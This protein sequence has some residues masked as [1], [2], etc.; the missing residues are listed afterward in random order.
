MADVWKELGN[1]VGRALKPLAEIPTAMWKSLQEAASDLAKGFM[2]AAA[3]VS[4]AMVPLI[5]PHMEE[6]MEEATATL[7][8]GSPK[9]EVK[10]K[11]DKLTKAL[12]KAL[13]KNIPEKGESPPSLEALLVATSAIISTNIGLDIG[14]Y[15]V[16]MGLDLVHPI[17]EMGFRHAGMKLLD[18]FQ[19]PSMIGPS[20]QA[21]VWSG[22]IAPL[23]MRWNE[24]FPYLV[25]GTAILPYMRAKDIITSEDYVLN[26]KF[27]AFDE[28]WSSAML[29]NTARYPSFSDLR[30]MIHRTDLTWEDAEVALSKS[31]IHADY[32]AKYEEL[33]PAIP[34]S[35][36]LITM[37]VREVITKAK[38]IENMKLQGFSA[39]W[40][41]NYY[42]NHWILLP[43]SEVKKARHRDDIDDAEL[44]KFLVLHDYKPD[45]R[46][47]I[48]TSDAGLA[49]G[50]IWDRPGRI[51]SRWMFRWGE[52]D[53]TDLRDFLVDDGLDPA[54]ADRVAMAVA[55]NQFLSDINRQIGNAKASFVK[56]YS[57][58]ATL[59]SD[60]TALGLRSE[61]VEYHVVD[62]LADRE[63]AIHDE[64]LRTL[65]AQY[66]R[67][68]M[69]MADVITAVE[70]I[71]VDEVAR[72]AW[73]KALPT[74]KQVVI[75][76]E[77]FGTE[78]NRLV[79][80]AKYDYVR[81]YT[82]KPNMVSRMTLLD[83]PTEVIEFH[84][85]DADEDRARGH[86]DKSLAIIEEGYIDDLISWELVASMAKEILVDVDGL[87][88]FL[89]GVWLNKHKAVR[90][91]V[92]E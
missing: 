63:R 56:G 86:K 74:A 8:P 18:S 87:N 48:K 25:P 82:T 42:E 76:E 23:R 69:T 92:G 68:A 20:L 35:G 46:P 30:T 55:K 84:V 41:D 44:S 10:E 81:G 26:M 79:A 32:V 11:A 40:A 77:T 70:P 17:K 85:M 89:D 12:M 3:G 21:P 61:M 4:E 58:E 67:G 75:M 80:N 50:L 6:L 38:F 36:D 33:L 47:D 5:A 19:L 62:A 29:A 15:G 72:D 57:V 83:L 52:I 59:R 60:I 90:V 34:G 88:L 91:F 45:P 16:T 27:N 39:E 53:A 7:L 2:G 54:Y 64:E 22:V 14:L 51:E 28:T 66:A 71:I 49:A 31:L 43:L 73:L 37:M 9:K 78:V 24:K 1:A 65:R 13:E